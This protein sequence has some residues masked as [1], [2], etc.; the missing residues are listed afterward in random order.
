MQGLL[1][2]YIAY[3]EFVLGNKDQIRFLSFTTITDVMK[4][5]NFFNK[6]NELREVSEAELLGFEKEFKDKLKSKPKE[7]TNMPNED[8]ENLKKKI[9]KSV[10]ELPNYSQAIDL[11]NNMISLNN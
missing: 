11:F 7:R 10:Q 6:N 8:R 2:E 1:N 5:N 3:Y 9:E 4:L